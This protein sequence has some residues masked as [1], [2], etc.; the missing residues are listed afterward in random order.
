MTDIKD[1]LPANITNYFCS[2]ELEREHLRYLIMSQ[3]WSP[4][5]LTVS[6]GFDQQF[7]HISIFTQQG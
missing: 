1:G 2:S 7:L 4:P 3:T 5:V 6:I